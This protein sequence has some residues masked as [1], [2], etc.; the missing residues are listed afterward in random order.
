MKLPAYFAK[1]IES[2]ICPALLCKT[3][4]MTTAGWAESGGAEAAEPGAE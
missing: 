4:Q 2:E 1:D 3:G